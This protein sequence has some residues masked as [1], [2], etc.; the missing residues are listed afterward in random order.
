MKRFSLKRYR[1]SAMVKRPVEIAYRILIVL[2]YLVAA[3]LPYNLSFTDHLG[4]YNLRLAYP[5]LR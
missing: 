1:E 4:G 3:S 2:L 5:V